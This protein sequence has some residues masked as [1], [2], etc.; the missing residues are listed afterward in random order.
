MEDINLLQIGRRNWDEEYDLDEHV[1]VLTCLKTST[2]PCISL[3]R[4]KKR[5]LTEFEE[6]EGQTLQEEEEEEEEEE[7]EPL[8]H[9]DVVL[10]TSLDG[11]PS[12]DDLAEI[13]PY[14]DPYRTLIDET[15]LPIEDGTFD[16]YMTRLMAERVTI[17]D[18]ETF[19]SDLPIRYFSRPYGAKV[20]MNELSVLDPDHHD[21]TYCGE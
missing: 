7:F 18:P 5:R 17:Q 10:I 15:I 8:P 1:M 13:L 12:Y 20:K 14:V 2:S 19:V 6:A 11:L 3:K 4:Q 16:Y 9:M 21:L